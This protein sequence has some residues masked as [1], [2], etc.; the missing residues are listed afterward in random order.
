VSGP[1][2]KNYLQGLKKELSLVDTILAT[3]GSGQ[4]ETL[5]IAKEL[6]SK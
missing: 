2:W 6:G 4:G 3:G 5:T 1:S